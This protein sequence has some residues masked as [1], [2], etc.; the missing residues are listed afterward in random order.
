MVF[1]HHI[2]SVEFPCKKSYPFH[3][4]LFILITMIIPNI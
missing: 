4:Y 3:T 1:Y 2:F